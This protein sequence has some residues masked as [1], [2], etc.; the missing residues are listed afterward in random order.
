MILVAAM[1]SF[2]LRRVHEGQATAA[3][4][5]LLDPDADKF[6]AEMEDHT[7]VVPKV[8]RTLTE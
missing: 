5:G 7:M 3:P 2:I 1:P 8:G 6:V 4:S